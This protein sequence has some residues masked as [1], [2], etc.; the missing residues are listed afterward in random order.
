MAPWYSYVVIH[1]G[2]SVWICAYPADTRSV[3]EGGRCTGCQLYSS[4]P[5]RFSLL[6][7]S[8]LISLMEPV[9]SLF[10]G[11][12]GLL[13]RD[14]RGEATDTISRYDP[15]TGYQDRRGVQAHYG[16]HRTRR[17]PGPAGYLPVRHGRSIRDL[18]NLLVNPSGNTTA[19]ECVASERKE[20]GDG[21]CEVARDFEGYRPG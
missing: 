15:V 4:C 14:V 6:S 3:A 21:S 13:K 12:E 18:G 1:Q 17:S 11:D 20:I 2:R 8:S 5:A 16:P 10:K 7:P 9:P 19:G